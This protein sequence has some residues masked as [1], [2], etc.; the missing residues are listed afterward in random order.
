MRGREFIMKDAYSFDVDEEEAKTSYRKMYGAYERIFR[1]CGLKF[2]AVDA[3]TG[4]IGGAYSHEFQVLAESGEDQILCC[5]G[6]DYASNINL[7]YVSEIPY[8][9]ERHDPSM[10]SM[11]MVKTPGKKSVNEV[12]EFLEITPSELIKSLIY[13]ADSKPIAVLIRGDHELNELKL[14]RHLECKKLRIATEEEILR[15]TSCVAGYAGPIGLKIK[16]IADNAIKSGIN[17]VT[18]A[19]REDH[20]YKN[21]NIPR[22]FSPDEYADLHLAVSGDR[23]PRCDSEFE[24]HRGI[25]VGQVFYLGTKYSE[26]MKALFSDTDGEKRPIVMGCYGIGVGRTMAAAIEQNHDELGIVWPISIAPFQTI[27]IPL[28][29]SEK[30]AYRTAEKIYKKLTEKGLEVL[31]DDRDEWAGVKFKDADLIGI[32]IRVIVGTR[33]EKDGKVEISSRDGKFKMDVSES[34]AVSE[35]MKIVRSLERPENH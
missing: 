34:D 31:F 25:E 1:R 10:K 28:V 23:C 3:D 35:T 22:D 4:P 6:C 15:I 30:S 27:V 8:Q 21:V 20:H 9:K 7:A 11:Q 12:S 24:W 18:G 5:K 17:W 14:M 32:P 19:N 2:R 13:V 26:S 33:Y 16:T 29:A